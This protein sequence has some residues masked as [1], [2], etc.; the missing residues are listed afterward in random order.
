MSV[1]QNPVVK[2]LIGEVHCVRPP[3]L[4]QAV[5]GSCIAIALF[6]HTQRL[7]GMAHVLLPD[8]RDRAETALPGKFADK[9]VDCLYAGLLELGARAERLKA[10]FAGG[11]QMFA[12]VP[13][14]RGCDIGGQNA[15]AVREA[16]QR[17]K[18][19]LL[20]EDSGGNAGRKVEFDLQSC[21]MM[22]EGFGDQR[23]EI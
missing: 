2:V 9:A 14:A 7:G 23:R 13:Q 22:V 19:G 6:D 17:L 12:G 4:L 21:R 10:K 20:A 5:V 3:Y 1:E 8:S 15:K 18:I 16:L 11:A